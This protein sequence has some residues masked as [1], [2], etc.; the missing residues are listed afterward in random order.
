MIVVL[1]KIYEYMIIDLMRL[2]FLL[3]IYI[4]STLYLTLYFVFLLCWKHQKYKYVILPNPTSFVE[5]FHETDLDTELESERDKKGTKNNFKNT[6]CI[7][8][9]LEMST[10]AY[11]SLMVPF[12]AAVIAW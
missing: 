10:M 11:A 7:G 3:I 9:D 1:S 12:G 6:P 8:K 2:L 4:S 5:K